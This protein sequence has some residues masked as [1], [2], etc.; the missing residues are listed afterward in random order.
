MKKAAIFVTIAIVTVL[1]VFAFT[2]NILGSKNPAQGAVIAT[3]KKNGVYS[4]NETYAYHAGTNT[5]EI[6]VGLDEGIITNISV[7]GEGNIDPISA[8]Y[9]SGV[10]AALPSLVVGKPV[11]EVN[12]PKQISGSSLTTA[13]VNSYLHSL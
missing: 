8:H 6:S 12:L 3:D 13:T 4:A 2:S 10:N 9:I 11:N 7:V 5:I 1:I